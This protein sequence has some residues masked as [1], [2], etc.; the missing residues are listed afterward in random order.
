MKKNKVKKPIYKRVWFWLLVLGVIGA[1]LGGGEETPRNR[2]T[3]TASNNSGENEVQETL[4]V[5]QLV[6]DSL[7]ENEDIEEDSLIDLPA[8]EI[9]A[10]EHDVNIDLAESIYTVFSNIGIDTEQIASFEVEEGMFGKNYTVTYEGGS[11]TAY[12][13]D[14]EIVSV[15]RDY[16]ILYDNIEKITLTIEDYNVWAA[17]EKAREEE[18]ARTTLTSEETSFFVEF[19]KTIIKANLKAP[20]TADFAGSFWSPYEGWEY[21]RDGSV[22]MIKSYVDSQ[23]SF[24]AMIRTNFLITYEYVGGT[25]TVVDIQIY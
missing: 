11:Y 9:F 1:V 22:V 25:A 12:T 14:K 7:I 3:E 23:N 8:Y 24:G 15:Q 18:L 13:N 16:F 20:S 4:E 19:S 2:V 5:A 17:E 6:S 10:K 21:S